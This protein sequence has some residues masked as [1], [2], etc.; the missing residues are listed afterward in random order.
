MKSS[1][2]DEDVVASNLALMRTKMI[3][4]LNTE[5]IG[6][7]AGSV[8]I[9]GKCYSCAAANMYVDCATGRI[10]VFGNIQNIDSRIKEDGANADCGLHVAY[11]F[12]WGFFRILSVY[13]WH[14]GVLSD[15]ARS[16]IQ[17]AIELYNQAVVREI[18]PEG[19]AV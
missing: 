6:G 14:P 12:D 2:L 5:S 1:C 17:K 11:S 19:E 4:H 7:N 15:L 9:D 16:N 8:E 10:L 13:E 3:K 18:R